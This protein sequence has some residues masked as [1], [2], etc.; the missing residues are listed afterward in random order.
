MEVV[1]S[2]EDSEVEFSVVVD[3][4]VNCLAGGLAVASEGDYSED[5]EVVN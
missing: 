1:D 3:W 5:L 4:E 2:A